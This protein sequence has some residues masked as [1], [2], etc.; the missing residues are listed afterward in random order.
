MWD[1]L[2]NYCPV[3][4]KG[5]NAIKKRKEKMDSYSG[6]N[7]IKRQAIFMQCTLNWMLDPKAKR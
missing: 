5:D 6:F 7:K 4:F 3:L 2:S 1:G